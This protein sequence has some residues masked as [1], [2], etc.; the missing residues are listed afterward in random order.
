[1]STIST[2]SIDIQSRRDATRS[3]RVLR[4]RLRGFPQHRSL[5]WVLRVVFALPYIALAVVSDASGRILTGAPNSAL[6]GA[7]IGFSFDTIDIHLL[8]RLYPPIT[9]ILVSLVPGGRL[10][11]AILG[12]LVAGFML[13]RL[14]EIMVQRRFA[15]GTIAILMV[16]LAANPL[17]A[18]T[19]IENFEGMLCLA[20]FGI[21]LAD[22]VRFVAWNDT[23]AG[24]RAGLLYMGAVLS[25]PAGFI[26]VLIAIVTA[27]FLRLGRA[28]QPGARSANVLIL[29]YPTIAALLS[30]AFLELIFLGRPFGFLSYVIGGGQ[31]AL[32]IVTI[33]F[34]TTNGA[35]VIAPVVSAWVIALIVRKPW[36]ILISTLVFLGVVM[37]AVYGLLPT[38]SAGDT[39]ILMVVMAI[40]LIPTARQFPTVLLVDVVATAQIAI[41]WLAAFNRPIVL[42]WLQLLGLG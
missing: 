21:G 23:R 17:F 25:S 14:L 1:M 9:T 34:T 32:E 10:G 35:L 2:T 30:F 19:A 40:A 26:Y 7:S 36:A 28:N 5:R 12:A 37:S 42:D 22:T 11:I 4:T 13:Q 24:F 27:P 6:F 39:F 38:N 16:A 31:S 18:Y 8:E 20:L 33:L 41:A 15:T 3:E 29:A